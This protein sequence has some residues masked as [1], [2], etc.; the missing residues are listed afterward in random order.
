VLGNYPSIKSS[1]ILLYDVFN[2]ILSRLLRTQP[3]SHRE[4]IVWQSTAIDKGDTFVND[5]TGAVKSKVRQLYQF[6]K[7][8]NQ[9]RFR[10]VRRLGDQP[11]I[12][13]LADMPN[14]ESVQLTRPIRIENTEEVPDTL[15]RIRRPRVTRCPEPPELIANWLLPGWDDPTKE[16]DYAESQNISSEREKG[17]EAQKG[18]DKMITVTIRFDDDEQRVSDW[19]TW[20]DRRTAWKVPEIV[21]RRAMG[22]FEAFYDIYSAIEKDG[23][24]LEL[25]AAD[26]HLSWLASSSLDGKVVIDHP[27]LLKRVELRFDPKVPEFSI[28]ETDRDPE[29]YG[30]LFVD[31]HDVASVAIQNRKAELETATYHPL[32]WG[33]TEAFLAA[34]IQTVS[35]L[36][37]EFLDAPANDLANTTPRLWRNPVFILRR[38]I[39]GIAN[40]VD[41]ILDDI[42]QQDHFPPA[43]AQITG[44]TDSWEGAGLDGAVGSTGLVSSSLPPNSTFSDDDIL[45]AKEAN[46]EQMQIIRRLERSGSV[47]VQGPPGTGKTHTIGNLIGHMLAQGKSILVT[48]Q[49]AKALRVLRDKV[50]E[51]LQPLCVSVLGSDQDARHQLESSIG[52]ITERLTGDTAQ[53]LQQ[54]ARQFSDER[55]RLLH[56]SQNLAHKLKEALENEYREIVVGDQRFTPSDAAR[57]VAANGDAHGWIPFPAKLGADLTLSNEQLVRL[58][59]LGTA[60]TQAEEQDARASLPD[61]GILPSER[62]FQVMVTEH[63]QLL[64]TD[65]TLGTDRWQSVGKTFVALESITSD[66]N[67]EFSDDLRRQ[68]WRPYAIVAGMHGGAEREVW[69][70]LIATIERAAD[71]NAKHALVLHHRPR[72]SEVMPVHRQ[73]EITLEIIEHLATGGKLSFLQLITRSEWR[74][75]LKTVSVTAGQ[76]NHRDHFEAI[77]HLAELQ[78]ARLELEDI[79]NILLG[80]HINLQFNAMGASPELS[81]RSLIPEICRCLDWHSKIW[82]PMAVKLKAEGLKLDDIVAALPREAC[83]ISEYLLLE[84]LAADILPPLIACEAGRRKIRE[85]DAWF[86]RLANL[87][88]QVDPASPEKGCAGKIVA[89]VRSRS[90]SGYASALE[91]ARRL[92]SVKP[93]VE[94]RDA[95]LAQLQHV[96]PGLAEHIVNR[97][98]PH[99]EGQIPGDHLMA[100]KW[101]QLRDALAERDKLDAHQLQREIDKTRD[102]LRQITQWL[103]DA[104]A[105]GKQLERLQENNAIRQALVGWLDTTKRLISTRQMDRRHTLL[106][107]SR[108]LMKLCSKAVPVWI[109][110]IPIMA[111]NFDPRTTRFDVVIIDEASQADLNALI[112]LY[113][114]KQVVIVGD[115]EQVT[116]L[117]V[118][119]DQTILEHLRK[120]MLQNI[121]NSHLF[122][123]QSSIYDIGR[124]SFGDAVRLVEHFRCV[125]EIIA[126]SNQLSYDGKIRPLRESNSTNIKPACVSCRVDGFREGDQ[127]NAEAR[128]I[129]D[130]IKAMIRH[131]EYA[132]KT[133]GVISMLGESQGILI[134]SMLQKEIDGVEIEKRRIQSGISGEFQGDERDIMFLSMVDGAPEA[135]TLRATREGAFEL[136][137]KR[138]N[139]ATSRARDQ[140]WVMH[141]FDPD[142]NLKTDDLRF[143]LLQHIKD[144]LSTL[145]AFDQ[146]VSK[147]ESPFEREVLKRLTGAGYRVKTQW[148]VGYFR[149]DMVVEG[150]GKRLAVE[151]DGDRYHPMEKL[152]EDME[153]QTILERLGWH[154][155]R[156]RGTAFYRD[157]EMAMRPVFERLTELEIPQETLDAEPLPSDMTLVH[158]LDDMIARRFEEEMEVIE[159]S[160]IP[161]PPEA[162]GP[163]S[164]ESAVIGTERSA[165]ATPEI[166]K[167]TPD[168]IDFVPHTADFDH[169]QIEAYL[170]NSGGMA[171]LDAFLRDI[172]KANGF[173]RLGRNVRKELEVELAKL[174]RR[175]RISIQGG[176]IRLLADE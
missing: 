70:K 68:T 145:R 100:W 42:E 41:A 62:Q 16:A 109:M 74:Q 101:R 155:V 20:T 138:Y 32:G 36:K 133:I 35:P 148:Q 114:G 1:F 137:K 153:R 51:V 84:K 127:N 63:Q 149:I 131:P 83:Q 97:I 102:I 2:G 76:P 96:A 54:K 86:D 60:C 99:N 108:K 115:H 129:I 14:H 23:E 87:S 80:R 66:L 12:V 48:A 112:P 139:V 98:P 47:I 33:D 150:A 69:E 26:G 172:A 88:F 174:S 29:L 156:I 5:A 22:F 56:Y 144:P 82:E 43:L 103:I 24:Q 143:K 168:D 117:G 30:G 158:E 110:P 107:E 119:K 64:T 89:A 8:A 78:A 37:G 121:P 135:G 116:P 90:T 163:T 6:L 104:R 151:C 136:I 61:L 55:K 58:Y 95:L 159:A 11:K 49:T 81:C 175:G 28:H 39:L 18:E 125:P 106:T 52:S 7:E 79:W 113:M 34:F 57:F 13:R 94:E 9:L 170:G 45:L 126:F 134:Q 140:M 4:P 167:P 53:S 71:A 111:E 77:G 161:A 15:L 25:I 40:A 162:S 123:S 160:T 165:H 171:P 59:A 120:S 166:L 3:G 132:G 65:L 10:P 44:T 73:R 105:W 130:T 142:L 118:G 31:L 141:S 147:T 154:F 85:C 21:A 122:D 92:H 46:D 128:R 146:E 38:R 173:Q 157:P 164:V 19:I 27:I 93:L 91:Y 176:V 72:L 152:A 169:G 67:A 17:E 124:Q 50:P 75:F